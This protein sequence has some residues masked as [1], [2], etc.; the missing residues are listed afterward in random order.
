M[1]TH[2]CGCVNTIDESCGAIKSL[3][4][5]GHHRSMQRECGGLDMGYYESIG[6][7]V[8]G[9]PAIEKHVEEFRECLGDLPKGKLVLEIGSG[10]SLYVQMVTDAECEYEAVDPSLWSLSWVWQYYGLRNRFG[11]HC[12]TFE[13]FE[14]ADEK[15]DVVLAIHSLEHM[16]DLPASLRKIGRILKPG[17]V[18]YAIIP[19]DSDLLNPDHLW[20]VNTVTLTRALRS[21]GL[22]VRK[23]DKKKRIER[24]N[25]LYCLAEKP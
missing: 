3:T 2:Q 1:I 6:A 23:M 16:P 15:Y 14:C 9:V 8:D 24:E 17:G 22:S 12:C 25:F 18:L 10:A 5:C 7:F 20:F 13:E 19:D 21:A 11:A 4:K